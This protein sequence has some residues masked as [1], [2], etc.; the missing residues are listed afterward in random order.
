MLAGGRRSISQPFRD[1]AHRPVVALGV[2][3]RDGGA[4]SGVLVGT[5]NLAGADVLEP[6]GSAERL[7]RTG[8]AEL[9]GPGGIALAST[10]FDDVLQPGEHLAFYRKMLKAPN[11][12][13]GDVAHTPLGSQAVGM[14]DEKHVMAFARLTGAPWG[15][16]LGGTESETFA[17][18]HR[19]RRTL[20]LAGTSSLAALWLLTLF[21]ARFLVRPV[22]TLTRSAEEMAS[23][24]LE[25]PV[26]V[27]EG[28]EI[29]VLGESLETMRSQ[30]RD[31][32]ETVRRWGEELEL[33]VAERTGELNARN[34]QL[35]AVSAI[36]RVANEAHDLE[37]MLERC[38]DVVLDQTGMDAAAVRLVDAGDGRAAETVA[39]GAWSDFP[40]RRCTDDLCF[41][42]TTGGDP[43]Y[44]AGHERERQHPGCPVAADALAVLPLRGPSGVLGV[45][46]IAR[47]K[48]ELPSPEERPV[49]T[50]I[51]DQIAVAIENARLA[52]ELRRLEA[53]HEVQRMRSELISAVSHELRTPLGF[54]KSYATTLLREDT[55]I[56][57]ETRRKFLG[58]IDEET[59][60]L[61]H[62]IDELLDASRLQAGRLPIEREPVQL[63]ALVAR[64]VE[65][66]RPTL[67]GHE[68]ALKLPAERARR[69]RGRAPDRAGARQPAGERGPLLRAGLG[70]RGRPR[71]RGRAR[72]AQR[73]RPRRR[74]PVGGAGAD[75]RALLPRPE[76][77]GARHPRRRPRPRDIARHRRGARRH[78]L[79]RE[80]AG[81]GDELPRLAAARVAAAPRAQSRRVRRDSNSSSSSR[82]TASSVSSTP[83]AAR[84]ASPQA[85]CSRY[86]SLPTRPCAIAR[87]S[88]SCWN[89]ASSW[90]ETLVPSSRERLHERR[91]LL[92]A[93][94][95]VARH[96]SPRRAVLDELEA[97]AALDAEVAARDVV[98]V[99]R[100]HLDDRRRPGRG[101]RGC[102][103][104]R[105]RGRPSAP[106]S[107]ATRPTRPPA[108]GRTRCFDISAPV[109][110]TAMQLP[111]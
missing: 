61:E 41:A 86:A 82:S 110:Q 37:T 25:R 12:G 89:Q 40:C 29:G 46:T 66:A 76:L 92:P 17:P 77:E 98:V 10:E 22:R 43:L 38:L 103:R 39:R 36:M 26:S 72:P 60:K 64:S 70:D 24:D 54:I 75:L 20:L 13:T 5:F 83:P 101:A 81:E 69:P 2:P 58:T 51:C 84:P 91:D 90:R 47:R 14:R 95:L 50:A 4:L 57:P 104:R 19:L 7:G 88:I 6:L 55:P 78:D 42:A 18:A 33:K 52:S 73:H 109:G 62:M 8:H 23:G 63:V 96:A 1:A 28:G 21:G 45:L 32:L 53:R 31:S 111:Q 30:L 67:N 79:G 85:H 59:D 35:A 68:V 94:H 34:R 93:Q 108:A 106:R 80:R 102:S 71:G 56:E 16:A 15:V 65:K 105:S 99:G 107:G 11:P 49:L 27:S 48:G 74:D 97:E 9:V 44:L 87:R 100:G 3:V